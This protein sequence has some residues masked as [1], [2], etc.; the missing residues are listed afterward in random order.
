M[1]RIGRR[2]ALT[3]SAEPG[4][5]RTRTRYSH[6]RTTSALTAA[7]TPSQG[8]GASSTSPTRQA[9]QPEAWGY[10]DA[11]G[12]LHYG[13]NF[14]G[15]CYSRVR[16][17]IGRRLDDNTVKPLFSDDGQ[18]DPDSN[19][20]PTRAELARVIL[21]SLKMPI[22]GQKQVMKVLGKHRTVAGESFLVGRDLLA[23]DGTVLNRSWE[24]LS[25]SELKPIPGARPGQPQWRR[26]Y[27]GGSRPDEDLPANTFVL[28]VYSPHP[29]F[30]HLA[31]APTRPA[32]EIM[33]QIVLCI[34]GLRASTVSRLASRGILLVPSEVDFEEDDT[35]SDDNESAHPLAL[36]L[37][38][39]ASIAKA[40]VGS[41]AGAIPLV[42]DMPSEYI[43][44]VKL[45]TFPNDSDE[46]ELK[47]L[48]E[49]L[50]QFAIT[51][52]L[53]M[54]TTLGFRETTFANGA[55][56]DESQFKAH[57]E[58]GLEE[59]VG[60]LTQGFLWP[61]LMAALHPALVGQ[62]AP[63]PLLPVPPEIE[64]LVVWYDAVNLVTHDGPQ[65]NALEANKAM[66]IS[67]AATR[68]YI[69][70]SEAD[71]PTTEEIDAKVRRVQLM[72]VK[73]TVRAE[74]TGTGGISLADPDVQNADIAAGSGDAG[75]DGV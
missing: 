59:V 39:V 70:Y 50:T 33:E 53:P 48:G 20:D 38:N 55:V 14:V 37:I 26:S 63:S 29:Q 6:R 30:G 3:A 43:E 65:K 64:E 45:L 62:P 46:I 4:T 66:V 9:W 60:V 67:D 25:T 72:N 54:E 28:R 22:G 1:A 71:A 24:V 17:I 58:P 23:A 15:A 61:Q 19:I 42:Q 52:D 27:G 36:D 51:M 41:A 57:I 8:G 12:C 49:M 16:L 31:D 18:L 68:R 10:Y 21:N 13:A 40:N 7:G 35:A 44:K 32:L 47:K 5:Q 34:R 75:A 11:C 56:I 74:E 2:P 69:G 73:E